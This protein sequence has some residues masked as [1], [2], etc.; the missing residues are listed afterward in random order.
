MKIVYLNIDGLII[1]LP[2]MIEIHILLKMLIPVSPSISSSLTD[3]SSEWD[4]GIFLPTKFA[5]MGS[6]A[7][8]RSTMAQSCMRAGLLIAIIASRAARDVRH[9]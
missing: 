3:T 2:I 1:I 7:C 4:V 8:P 6:S 9:V 5:F